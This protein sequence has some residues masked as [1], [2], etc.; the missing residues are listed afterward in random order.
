MR[1]RVSDFEFDNFRNWEKIERWKYKRE[2]KV[3]VRGMPPINFLKRFK[4][5]LNPRP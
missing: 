2:N 5:D 1:E 3:Q 4:W